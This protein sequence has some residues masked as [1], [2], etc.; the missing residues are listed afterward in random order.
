[1]EGFVG[2]TFKNGDEKIWMFIFMNE[3]K[4]VWRLHFYL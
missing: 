2:F 1:M 4:K 3:D